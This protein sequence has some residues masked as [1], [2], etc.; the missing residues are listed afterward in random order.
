M[1]DSLKYLSERKNTTETYMRKAVRSASKQGHNKP[2]SM[3]RSVSARRYNG[4][5]ARLAKVLTL[6]A[7]GPLA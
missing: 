3:A 2:R 6:Q 1:D 7:P 5:F 4:L